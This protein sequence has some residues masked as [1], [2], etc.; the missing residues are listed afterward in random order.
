MALS[1]DEQWATDWARRKGLLSGNEVAQNGLLAARI[2]SNPA[3]Q[4]EFQAGVAAFRN[5][6]GAMPAHIE[7]LH[8]GEKAGLAKQIIPTAMGGGG[9]VD[10]QAF[11]R[12][13][14]ANPQANSAKYISPQATKMLEKGSEYYGKADNYNA[15]GA[16]E[17]TNS[18]IDGRM[19]P[20]DDMI[21]ASLN[22][23]SESGQKA[24]DEILR[25]LSTRGAASFGDNYSAIR[26]AELDK[27]LLSKTGDIQSS[28]RYQ[29]RRDS[30]SDIQKDRDR[31]LQ[32]GSQYAT[33]GNGSISGANI[34][35]GVMDSGYNTA[36]KLPATLFDMGKTATDTGYQVADRQ[37]AAGKYV[38][39]YNQNINDMVADDYLQGQGYDKQNISQ[40]L[41]YAPSYESS[42]N[43]GER[44]KKSSGLGRVLG[45]AAQVAGAFL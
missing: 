24:K 34:A 41:A 31:Q 22:R 21:N 12:D 33:L 23:L 7:Q 29:G 32:A 38:R 2:A 5:Q 30:V 20:V 11:L 26:M 37:V 17:I 1:P 36:Q 42:I 16:R 14:I 15:Q 10:G 13:F 19:I 6:S 43:V 8:D 25:K 3:L 40:A 18:E 45:T 35:Q 27:E 9:M 39:D 4:D 44:Q 28:Y